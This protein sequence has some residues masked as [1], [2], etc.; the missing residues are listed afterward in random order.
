MNDDNGSGAAPPGS[1]LFAAFGDYDSPVATATSPIQTLSATTP[2]PPAPKTVEQTGLSM[3]FLLEHI[4]KIVRYMETPAVEH[5]ARVACLSPALT[6]DLIS[7]MRGDRL[8]EYA[9][10]S[11]GI[12]GN[13]RMRLTERGE[14]RADLAL[15]RCRYA[16]PAPVTLNDYEK[17]TAPQSGA[18]WRPSLESVQRAHEALVLD[19]EVADLLE[20]AIRSGRSTMIYGPSGN[21]KTTLLT[22]FVK[23]LDGDVVVPHA[24]YAQG[25]I[26]RVF[27]R[28]VHTKIESSAPRLTGDDAGDRRWVRIRRPGLIVGGE[29]TEESLELGFDPISRF[30]Q[31]PKH[32]K[33]QSGVLVVDD[34][35]RQK[36]A[37]GDLL[38]RWML[39][40]EQGRD[41]LLLRTGES[42]DIPFSMTL[43]F[44]TNLIPSEITD[45]AYLRRI[46]YKIYMPPSVR[47]QFAEIARR[48][49]A[50]HGVAWAEDELEKVVS[51]LDEATNHVLSGSLPRDIVTILIDNAEHEG[52]TPTFDLPSIH[53]AYRQFTGTAAKR[54]EPPPAGQTTV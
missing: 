41:N 50:E 2:M 48:V 34:F 42:I 46:I 14:A 44:S 13:F 17:V 19:S 7:I 10:G 52:H 38:N 40:L 47:E 43:L 1:D 23:Y 21:G 22:E 33:A 8:L 3:S 39:A 26:I 28:L 35:G 20:R 9:S 16:G 12:A 18:H 31:A 25:Q 11:T 6:T 54:D 27:D 36:V 32:V 53:L 30:Y 37:P 45:P 29:L 15:E 24:L 4:L 5:I 51:F 49:L